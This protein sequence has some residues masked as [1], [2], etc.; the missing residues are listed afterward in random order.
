MK[1][2][3]STQKFTTIIHIHSSR[4][5][6]VKNTHTQNTLEGGSTSNMSNCQ[7]VLPHSSRSTNVQRRVTW[8]WQQN[9]HINKYNKNQPEHTCSFI[10][11]QTL[12]VELGNV[13]RPNQGHLQALTNF[14]ITWGRLNIFIYIYIC[15]CVCVCVCVNTHTHT[16]THLQD[17]QMM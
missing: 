11:R 7:R 2:F 10:G 15:V 16:H 8:S 4:N 14:K 3:S 1:S 13:F 6:T 17:T 12:Y 5:D 9:Y